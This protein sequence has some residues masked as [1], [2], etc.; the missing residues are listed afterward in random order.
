MSDNNARVEGKDNDAVHEADYYGYE[1]KSPQ[2]FPFDEDKLSDPLDDGLAHIVNPSMLRDHG[3]GSMALIISMAFFAL[4]F[5]VLFIWQF[6]VAECKVYR[7]CDL[8]DRSSVSEGNSSQK[9]FRLLIPTRFVWTSLLFASIGL[10]V[11]CYYAFSVLKRDVGTPGMAEIAGKIQEGCRSFMATQ[12]MALLLPLLLLFIL[13]GVGPG[14]RVAGA[15]A[16]GAQLTAISGYVCSSIATAGNVRTAAAA[17]A[18]A[19]AGLNVAF[20]SS[21]VVGLALISIG[22]AGA[23]A[24]YLM[25]E[26]VRALGGFA[27]GASA[28]TLFVRMAGGLFAKA[29]D[30]GAAAT[31]PTR[32]IIPEDDPTNPSSLADNVGDNIGNVVGAGVDL[33]ESFVGSVIATA[34]LGSSLPFFERNQFSMCVHNHLYI[35][36]RCGAFG[37]PQQ[38]SFATYICKQEDLYLKYPLLTTWQSNSAFVA[39]PFLIGS[40]G[41][42]A[43]IFATI[44]V[45]VNSSADEEPDKTV[46]V[47]SLLGSLRTNSLV[48]SILVAIGSAALCFGLFGGSSQF[49]KAQGFSTDDD[50]RYYRLSDDPGACKNKYL[51]AISD[52]SL[53]SA[54]L[55]PTGSYRNGQYRPL[56]TLGFHFGRAQLASF[57][58]WGCTLIGLVLGQLISYS[59]VYFTASSHSPTRNIASSGAYGPGAVVIEGLGVG[60]MS[61]VVP[62]AAVV[63]AILLSYNFFGFYGVGLAAV[64]MLSTLGYTLA[65]G[66]YGSIVD[67]AGGIAQMTRPKLPANVRETTDALDAVG[68]TTAAVGKGFANASSVLT[69]YALLA[70]LLHES[71][72][73]PSPV[74]VVGTPR[75]LGRLLLGHNDA[76][77][78]ADVYVVVSMFVGFMLPFLFSGLLLVA[79]SSM[80]RS[81]SL[82]A[83]RQLREI[84]GLSDGEPGVKPDHVSTVSMLTRHAIL[85]VAIPVA[86]V[87]MVPLIVGFGFGQQALIGMLVAAVGTGYVL[88][89]MMSNTGGAWDNAKKLVE[90][91]YFG[92]LNGSGSDWHSATQAADAVGDSL[93]DAAGP[94]LNV[95]IKMMVAASLITAPLM[96]KDRSL[97]WVGALL[98]LALVVFAAIVAIFNMSRSKKEQ[99]AYMTA[100]AVEGT[101]T[102]DPP[103]KRVSPFYEAGS[104]WDPATVVPG[105]QM[106]DA[107]V[108]R[109]LPSTPLDASRLAGMSDRDVIDM[110]NLNKVHLQ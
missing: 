60:M 21:A 83:R 72:L 30:I 3:R 79:V 37:Y 93:K 80:A 67:N 62:M 31:Q 15:F 41:V 53:D 47:R 54:N 88:A 101:E 46:V 58:L 50:L 23:T 51:E 10:L 110:Q 40:V 84:P 90:S 92:Q 36:E 69:A 70:A 44:Y 14:W 71:G 22:L 91:M 25:F 73:S 74:D 27:A 105:S 19:L 107:L 106:H 68:N 98:L 11:S 99:E 57:R 109:G 4:S 103:P 5:L 48:A 87:L 65:E 32:A 59:V 77:S 8:I 18:G 104:R 75:S 20:R 28:V 82:E 97:G 94:S 9:I 86:T 85:E 81:A 7:L 66:I 96:R 64:A 78:L 6:L 52:G 13:I 61:T 2:D 39:L 108:A 38:L 42:C 35:D 102:I 76:S 26:D 100:K 1:P 43:S 29:A 34:I 33:F 24:V 55:L 49:H 12:F 45:R 89:T 16:I 56:S 63:A 95:A 17:Q